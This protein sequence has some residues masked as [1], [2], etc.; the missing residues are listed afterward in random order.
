M[1]LIPGLPAYSA[2][3]TGLVPAASATDIWTIAGHATTKIYVH[4]FVFGGSAGTFVTVP[5]HV[6]KRSAGNTAGT[7]A[8]VAKVPFDASFRAADATVLAYTANPS[9]LG[10]AVGTVQTSIVTL[11]LTSAVLNQ[12]AF[13]DFPEPIVLRAA[14]QLL[15]VNLGAISVSSGLLNVSCVWQ[16]EP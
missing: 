4:R 2:A 1:R 16:E 12:T 13:V 10:T 14:T 6:I 11:A 3:S 5:F 8:A 7:S 15:A 9:A